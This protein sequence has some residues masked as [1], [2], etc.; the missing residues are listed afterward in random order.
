MMS[1]RPV[2]AASLTGACARPSLC[3]RSG[4]ARAPPLRRHRRSRGPPVQSVPR[5]EAAAWTCRCRDRPPR[6]WPRP[7]PARRPGP[8]RARPARCRCAVAGVPR[9]RGR[10]G[11]RDC[12][13]RFQGPSP[14]A[15]WRAACPAGW[16]SILRRPRT[17]R[18]TWRARAAGR[19][20]KGR[21]SRHAVP[22]APPSPCGQTPSRRRSLSSPSRS[23]AMTQP[24]K[25]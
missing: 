9:S 11:P 1:R 2:S 20:G 25:R 14:R 5:P 4:S 15:R 12:R 23:E 3:A 10:P 18:T 13:A 22:H 17:A 8:G 21:G 24:V 6:G 16:C 19:T 7:E